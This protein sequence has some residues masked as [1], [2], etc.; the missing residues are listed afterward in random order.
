MRRQW[1]S[2]LHLANAIEVLSVVLRISLTAGAL[3]AILSSLSALAWAQSAS[4]T[5]VSAAAIFNEKCKSCHEPAVE[6]APGIAALASYD[7]SHVISALEK[8]VMAPMARDLSRDQIEAVADYLT[9]GGRSQRPAA[10]AEEMCR[11]H[12]LMRAGKSD[13]PAPGL[14]DSSTRF[15]RHPGLRAADVSRLKVKWAVAMPG[16]GQPTV[17]GNW[18]FVTNRG[19]KFYALDAKTGCVHWAL[20]NASTR[21]TPIVRRSSISQS[22]W[23]VFIGGDRPVVRALDARTGESLWSSNLLDEHPAAYATGSPVASGQQ[24]FVPISSGEEVVALDNAY[25]CCS[26]RG[27]LVALDLQ[28]GRKQWQTFM[29]TQPLRPTRVNAAGVQMQGPAGAAIWAAPTVDPARGLVYAVTGDSYTEAQTDGADAV[30]AMEMAT[31][32][33]R[34]RNQ[35]TADDNF[36]IGCF[37]ARKA[38]NCP[39]PTGPDFDFGASPILFGK[40]RGGQIL[41]AAQK[42]GMVYGLEPDTGRLRWKTAV[43]AGSMLGGIEWGIGAD[44][45]RIFVPI[46]D[47][48][49][50]FDE[51]ATQAGRPA[52]FGYQTPNKAGLFALDP[53]SG[54][55][56]WNTPAPI[57]PCHYAGDRSKDLMQGACVRAQS[58]APGV[59]PGVVFSGTLDGWLRAYDV[60]SGKILWA[61]STTAQ[62][63][64]TVNGVSGQPGG[65]IDGMGPTIANGMVYIMSGFNGAARTGGNGIN[66]LLAFSVDG[67]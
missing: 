52:L 30:V 27:S 57:A 38:A 67:R 28:T 26:F 61:F 65:G 2:V 43:G 8:G 32:K 12:D 51:I 25:P 62:T 19:G 11:T 44:K 63:Y 60:R 64:D 23:A 17:I 5:S 36:V 53:F 50:L 47:I 55:I 59:I 3:P 56:L 54:K 33:V 18:L 58:A 35:V 14:D 29:I 6:R 20:E 48:G 40:R 4:A 39:Q 41:I 37:G 22:G 49:Q 45:R 21:T 66:V 15:Q 24:L 10:S 7:R 16:G 42:S 31:G 9:S 34:W 46:S 13:W 1:V